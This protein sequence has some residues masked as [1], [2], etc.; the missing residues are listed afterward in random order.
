MGHGRQDPET[1]VFQIAT[2]SCSEF[3]LQHVDVRLISPRPPEKAVPFLTSAQA[4]DRRKPL[5]TFKTPQETHCMFGVRGLVTPRLSEQS[6]E[7][8]PI[9]PNKHMAFDFCGQGAQQTY[10]PHGLSSFVDN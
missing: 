7:P 9:Y 8:C 3:G 2:L 10:T 6:F 1:C 4:C 5:E